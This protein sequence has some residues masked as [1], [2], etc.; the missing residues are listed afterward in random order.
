MQETAQARARGE[1][2]E[3]VQLPYA[4]APASESFKTVPPSPVFEASNSPPLVTINDDSASLF[5]TPE[6][7]DDFL[8][9]G[10]SDEEKVDRSD[11]YA[12]FRDN[13]T[14]VREEVKV[15]NPLSPMSWSPS[16]STFAGQD[17]DDDFGLG[18][19]IPHVK[20]TTAEEIEIPDIPWEPV[21]DD[22]T[23]SKELY[24]GHSTR[25]TA[26]KTLEGCNP[27]IPEIFARE[28]G[29]HIISSLTDGKSD[30]ELLA[31]LWWRRVW[32]LQELLKAKVAIFYCGPYV[33]TWTAAQA[34]LE[35]VGD[36][37]EL[38]DLQDMHAWATAP[39]QPQRSKAFGLSRLLEY[40]CS[41][42]ATDA[43]D[44]VYAL[45]SLAPD[46]TRHEVLSDYTLTERQVFAKAAAHCINSSECFDVLFS[47]WLRFP[48]QSGNCQ[49]ASSWVP[50]LATSVKASSNSSHC[51]LRPGAGRWETDTHPLYTFTRLG[52]PSVSLISNDPHVSLL[53]VKAYA[54]DKVAKVFQ[55]GSD[56]L[57][58]RSDEFA[59]PILSKAT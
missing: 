15:Q 18:V 29:K 51:L 4:P 31:L 47:R 52:P 36:F 27:A 1:L 53:A 44:K 12:I 41:K 20:I 6:N 40:T 54:V 34:I 32:I 17:H 13:K 33:F 39:E 3:D 45:L 30:E 22:H 25:P 16:A 8:S 21:S 43:R 24:L 10:T 56:M 37:R 38:V 26:A 58:A 48:L 5:S 57:S 23:P 2:Y 50:N 49:A 46:P 35:G 14:Q 28:L 55:I 19:E 9:A 11:N 42:G 7:F 59:Q